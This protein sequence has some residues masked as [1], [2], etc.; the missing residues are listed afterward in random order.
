MVRM[1][2]LSHPFTMLTNAMWPHL[3]HHIGDSRDH[4]KPFYPFS[5]HCSMVN[6]LTHA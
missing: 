6:F 5:Q 1:H 2:W 4:L 3:F